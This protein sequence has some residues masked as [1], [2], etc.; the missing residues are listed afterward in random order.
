MTNA[1]GLFPHTSR[2]DPDILLSWLRQNGSFVHD[3]L[4]ISVTATGWGV[5]STSPIQ[6]DELRASP[7]SHASSDQADQAVLSSSKTAVLSAR[8]TSL[9]LP[10]ELIL[11]IID[12]DTSSVATNRTIPTLALVVLHEIRLGEE[13]RFWGYLQSLPREVCGLPAFWN[14]EGEGRRWLKGTEA[15]R[16]LLRRKEAHMALVGPLLP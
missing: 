15:D 16:E 2:P 3:D 14:E 1:Q 7:S 10:D 5:K 8:T 13:G 12:K 9:Q 11:P 6:A 4:E